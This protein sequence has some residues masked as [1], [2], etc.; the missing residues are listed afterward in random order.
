M[1]QERR[2]FGREMER[3]PSFWCLE[4]SQHFIATRLRADEVRMLL[5]V[6]DQAILILPHL[7]KI[8]VFAE[9]LDRTFAV[10]A[11]AVRRHLSPSRT[12]HQM[13]STIQCSQPYKSVG[14]HRAV[15]DIVE[16]LICVERP[17]F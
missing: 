10:G 6:F 15:E 14:C 17:S 5:D 2:D 7:E 11:E 3:S 4:K 8:I 13:C 12:V 16:R 9:L 1:P